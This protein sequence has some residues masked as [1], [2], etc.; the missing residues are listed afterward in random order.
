MGVSATG[1]REDTGPWYPTSGHTTS[2][3]TYGHAAE[4]WEHL[5]ESIGRMNARRDAKRGENP[6]RGYPAMECVP[7]RVPPSNIT[8]NV[9]HA[10]R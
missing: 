3:C 10:L 2:V 8:F 7:A 1:I 4:A 9:E 5:Q 6:D